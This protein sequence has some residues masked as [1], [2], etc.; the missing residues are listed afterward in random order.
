MVNISTMAMEWADNLT[1]LDDMTN[2]TSMTDK[3]HDKY[4]SS[5]ITK[6]WGYNLK[7]TVSSVR[8]HFLLKFLE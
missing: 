7:T 6:T 1:N 8:N 3:E 4:V 2:L 5:I